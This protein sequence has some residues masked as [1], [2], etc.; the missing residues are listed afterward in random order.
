LPWERK[1]REF[2]NPAVTGNLQTEFL[3]D[4]GKHNIQSQG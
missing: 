1:L 3:P 4:S 2:V